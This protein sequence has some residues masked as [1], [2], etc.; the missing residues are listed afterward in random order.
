LSSV[1]V[2]ATSS[3]ASG[4]ESIASELEETGLDER[5]WEYLVADITIW[6]QQVEV[7][8]KAVQR[9]GRV[10]YLFANAGVGERVWVPNTTSS[11]EGE[12]IKPDLSVNTATSSSRLGKTD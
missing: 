10:D 11:L 12:Y 8:K 3:H 9:W 7:F 2:L 1:K 6:E 4:H 5:E